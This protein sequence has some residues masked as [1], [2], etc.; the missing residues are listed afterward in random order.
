MKSIN[1][2]LQQK[3]A[4]LQQLQDEVKALRVVAGWL[5]EDGNSPH[6]SAAERSPS[7]GETSSGFIFGEA[8]S[9]QFP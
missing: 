5:S 7:P 6:H 9:R 2:L 3:E 8:Q 4:E 1:D